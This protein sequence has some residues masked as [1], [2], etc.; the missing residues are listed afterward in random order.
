MRTI[1]AQAVETNS[2]CEE[3]FAI[4]FGT[5]ATVRGRIDGLLTRKR[6]RERILIDEFEAGIV[7]LGLGQRG[8]RSQ[9]HYARLVQIRIG[10][11]PGF[12]LRSV[13]KLVKFIA[14]EIVVLR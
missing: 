2:A 13:E 5:P 8:I 6:N 11:V 14:V 7:R 1:S 3:Y 4:F 10:R 9:H 12:C